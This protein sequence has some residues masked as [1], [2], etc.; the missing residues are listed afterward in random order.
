MVHTSSDQK[1][2]PALYS[3]NHAVSGIEPGNHMKNMHA[4]PKAIL[5]PHSVEGGVPELAILRAYP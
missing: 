2:F 1:L 4:G 5:P 3:K